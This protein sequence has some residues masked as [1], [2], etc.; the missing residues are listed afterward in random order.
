MLRHLCFTALFAVLSCLAAAAHARERLVWV[1]ED[2][3]PFYIKDGGY[4]KGIADRLVRLLQARLPQY[5]HVQELVPINRIVSDLKDGR[6]MVCISFLKSEDIARI[7]HYSV[8]TMLL[9]PHV[10]VMRAETASKLSGELDLPSLAGMRLKLGIPEGRHFSDEI[11]RQIKSLPEE[12]LSV[13]TGDHFEGLARMVLH[14][15]LDYTLAYDFELNYL[16]YTDPRLS[17]LVARSIHRNDQFIVA[18]AV[19]PKT[20]QG[21]RLL[22]NLNQALV[23]LRRQPEYKQAHAAWIT[24]GKEYEHE[25]L[26]FVRGKYDR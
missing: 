15:R 21:S 2:F 11:S 13:R 25:Y 7:A 26:K 3:P 22:E 16:K 17:S 24:I 20:I 5:H 18:H 19:V 12:F 4:E 14:G 8:A 9:P 23:E 6:L 1:I 10:A